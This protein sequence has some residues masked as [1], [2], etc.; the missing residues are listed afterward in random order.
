MVH[1]APAEPP[2]LFSGEQS[3]LVRGERATLVRTLIALVAIIAG[4]QFLS[5]FV[6]TVFSWKEVAVIIVVGMVYVTLGRGRLLGAG[7]RVHAR[8]FGRVREIVSACAEMLKMP[9]PQVFVRDDP[10]VPIVSVGL[11]EPYAIVISAQWVDHISPDELR[12]LVGRELGH[13]LAGHTRITSLLSVNGR[14][15]AVVSIIFGSW[16]RKIEY[17]ADRLGLLCA[18]SLDAAFSAISVSAF[19]T[20]GRQIDLAAFADQQRELEAEPSLRMGKWIS[21]SPYATNRIFALRSFARDRLYL[22]WA[23]RLDSGTLAALRSPETMTSPERISRK[24]FA[25]PLRRLYAWCIDF[26][27]VNALLPHEVAKNAQHFITGKP[28]AGDPA[29]AIPLANLVNHSILPVDSN[30]SLL[31]LFV[32]CVVLVGIAGQTCGMMIFDLRV[33]NVRFGKIGIGGAVRRYVMHVVSYVLVPI[34]WFRFW[35]R[36]Q[37]YEKWSRTRIVEGAQLAARIERMP[38]PQLESVW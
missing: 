14:E 4:A 26:A 23:Q 2:A 27:L 15:N 16:L 1:S 21:S 19:H 6:S 34:G 11:G 17:S 9:T 30:V 35:G 3:L 29:W 13:I 22:E 38:A 25:G 24:T 33:V 18:R 12:F 31:A 10:F 32:Y 36:V 8:Q 28:D 37:P 20:V 5:Y 7:I